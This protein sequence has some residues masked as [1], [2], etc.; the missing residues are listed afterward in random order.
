VVVVLALKAEAVT[1]SVVAEV[2]VI[3]RVTAR[4]VGKS[5]LD[6]KCSKHKS[7]LLLHQFLGLELQFLDFPTF[8]DYYHFDI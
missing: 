2:V 8:V 3:Q 6:L 1:I 4:T 7:S 5:S